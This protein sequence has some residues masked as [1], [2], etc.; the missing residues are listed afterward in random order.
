MRPTV[1]ETEES[2]T[3]AAFL[4]PPTLPNSLTQNWNP[5]E[6]AN[7][8]R[9][10][11]STAGAAAQLGGMIPPPGDGRI[12]IL[13]NVGANILTI[14]DQDAGSLAANRF[15]VGA[16]IV[17]PPGASASFIYDTNL[18]RYSAAGGGGGGGGGNLTSTLW[19]ARGVGSTVGQQALVTDVGAAPGIVVN[20]DGTF[21]KLV[22]P[23]FVFLN[24]T[25]VNG[26]LSAAEQILHQFSIQPGL[27]RAGRIIRF[28]MLAGDNG[29][30]DGA[31]YR[32]RLGPLG[33]IADPTI[34]AHA[35]IGAAF[36]SYFAAVFIAPSAIQLRRFTGQ[37]QVSGWNSPID[38]VTAY[39]QNIAIGDIDAATL[40]ASFSVQMGGTDI[41]LVA[42]SFIDMIP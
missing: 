15:A 34:S 38:S 1:F 9:I 37:D 30:V 19:A 22:A 40:I 6:I 29:V 23:S 3:I 4:T 12:I 32:I 31:T 41:P 21:W 33:T 35:S 14:T 17:I 13:T 39:P 20:W 25:P 2:L 42:H 26:V 18:L 16:G 36:S 24:V 27:L 28:G 5:G 11:F 10:R 8:S 7:I